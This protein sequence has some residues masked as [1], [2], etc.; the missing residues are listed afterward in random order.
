MKNSKSIDIVKNLFFSFLSYAMPTAVLQ[1]VIQPILANSLG[2]EVNGQYLTQ[3]SLN[4]LI[5]GATATV[6]NTTR[7][8]QD[9][10]YKA[11]GYVGDF[12]VFF[13]V[14]AVIIVIIVP[15][16]QYFYIGILNLVDIM[17]CVIITLL[18]LYHDYI[19]AQYRLQMQF[20]KILVNN[21]LLVVG[22]FVGLAVFYICEK[23]QVVVIAA[24]LIGG[25]FDFFNTDFLKEPIRITPMFS[26][27][28]RKIGPL[29]ISSILG[30]AITYCD[31]L[32]LFPLLGGTSVSIYNAASIIGKMLI[33]ISSPLN[34]VFLSYMV[35]MK[36][37]QL[38]LKKKNLVA[39]AVF[40]LVAYVACVFIGFPIVDFL[41][42]KWA[43]ESQKYIP[44]L[45]AANL[46][47]L[48]GNI[49]NTM[50]IRFYKLS[51]QISIQAIN[52]LIYLLSAMILWHFFSLMGFCIG[53]AIAGVCRILLL[54]SILLLQKP[55]NQN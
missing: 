5:I 54:I 15:I 32:I 14:Y 38:R 37:L 6:L 55:Q 23:W 25:I 42:P 2:S 20:N 34:S 48:V 13:V 45:V 41:Y 19:F 28:L 50:V 52:L 12:N 31:K 36:T 7:M 24:Y 44:V 47:S 1:F 18:Y 26:D 33:L 30:S 40:L 8:L 21:I 27:T 39:V 4:Y 49:I 10:E 3:M 17:L 46:F 22:Y 11:N 9:K 29:T 51:F 16:V 53:I 35:Q 43:D